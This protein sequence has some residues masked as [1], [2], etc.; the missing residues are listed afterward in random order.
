[1]HNM[2]KESTEVAI[3]AILDDLTRKGR[4]IEVQLWP[5]IGSSTIQPEGNRMLINE[6]RDGRFDEV[7]ERFYDRMAREY[8]SRG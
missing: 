7:D 5:P 1:M 3:K 4:R 6:G 2:S 8:D